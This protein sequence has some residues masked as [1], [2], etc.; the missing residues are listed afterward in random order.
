MAGATAAW[1]DAFR[2][3]AFRN[4]AFAAAV[5]GASTVALFAFI[6]WQTAVF[7]SGR[8]EQTVLNETAIVDRE[9]PQDLA[10]D[11]Q[12][13]FA[14]DLHR[15][16]FAALWAQ[17]GRRLAGDVSRYPAGLPPDG[18]TH[19][20]TMA[21]DTS[22]GP[23]EERVTALARRLTDGRTVV[24]GRSR[25]DLQ[26]LQRLVGR[27]LALGLAPAIALSLAAGIWASTR[28][29]SRVA[30]LRATLDR[31]IDS[32]LHERLPVS[33]ARDDFDILATSVN[34]ALDRLERMVAEMRG[35]GDGIAHNLRSPLARMRARLEGGRRR[36][37]TLGELDDV[38]VQAIADLDQCFGTITAL[39]RIG[40]LES[41]SRRSGFASVDLSA[42]AEEA[43]ELY[44]PIAELRGLRFTANASHRAYVFADRDLLF[45]VC[46]NLLD[47][48]IKFAAA[49]G[50]V[51][52]RVLPGDAGPILRVADDGPGI[53]PAEQE[54]VLQRFYR[55]ATTAHV[56][57]SGLGLSLV[58]AIL[59]LHGFGLRM[60]RLPDGFAADVICAP[61]AL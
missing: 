41:A 23:V 45:E 55:S 20:V 12:A 29:L 52:I 57:G 39:L 6:Y 35:L 50:A 3:S 32:N 34:R 60:H 28:T 2:T 5:F 18:R 1:T 7:E 59:R 11:L 31:I 25:R 42:M 33:A 37:A 10:R 47:N 46:A 61:R 38:A 56:A 30:V 53:P 36:A 16:S 54:A 14:G 17:D 26:E 13:R 51:S 49:G 58:A 27:A 8:I 43:A 15:L 21:R 9:P 24:V 40:E 22:G 44:Q 48:A 4:S 19:V